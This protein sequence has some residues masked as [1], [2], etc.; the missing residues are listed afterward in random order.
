MSKILLLITGFFSRISEVISTGYK[1]VVSV[2]LTPIVR[3][4]T[5]SVE[6]FVDDEDKCL[7]YTKYMMII[8]SCVLFA[9]PLGL[10]FQSVA[11]VILLPI[12]VFC[13]MLANSLITFTLEVLGA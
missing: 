13:W 3:I 11:L 1:I 2:L 4:I 8:M 7:F 9:L 6:M 12:F 5:Y 10:M